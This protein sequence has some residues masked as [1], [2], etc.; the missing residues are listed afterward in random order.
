MIKK[1]PLRNILDELL[2]GGIEFGV[3]SN[4]YGPPGSGKT[5]LCLL[6]TLSCLNNNS[7]VAY[8]DTE[9]GFSI[10]RFF[11]LGG[12][13]DLLKKVY[14]EKPKNFK[15]QLKSIRKFE[16]VDVQLIV[17]DSLVS[18]YRLEITRENYTE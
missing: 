12:T 14:Y 11:Q 2:R 5:N 4:F 10:E 13:R 17:V 6:Y 3:I 7:L 18:L 15:E 9:N 8:I 16:K 1:L